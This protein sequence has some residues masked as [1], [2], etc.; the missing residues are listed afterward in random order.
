MFLVL[1]YLKPVW[2]CFLAAALAAVALGLVRGWCRVDFDR[3]KAR[4]RWHPSLASRIQ[5][6]DPKGELDQL[7]FFNSR[8]AMR[9]PELFR[10][11][12]E[13]MPMRPDERELA[14]Q[15]V[16]RYWQ[17]RGKQGLPRGAAIRKDAGDGH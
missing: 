4:G 16:N 9:S 5:P 3:L 17:A 6:L 13:D 15:L 14:N 1:S 11:A 7:G 12:I 10:I 8:V 2:P